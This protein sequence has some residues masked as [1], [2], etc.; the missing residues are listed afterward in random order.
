TGLLSGLL[1]IPRPADPA[2][3]TQ[4]P[5]RQRRLLLE[6]L[7]RWLLADI[8]RTPLLLVVEDLHWADPSTLELLGPWLAGHAPAGLF[9]LVTSRPEVEL[10]AGTTIVDI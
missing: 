9:L 10:P 2:S 5:Q 3:R 4:S 6:S 8:P 1:S 7:R